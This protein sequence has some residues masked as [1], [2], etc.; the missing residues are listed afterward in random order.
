MARKKKHQRSDGRFEYKATVGRKLDG[1]PIR[2]S[3][4]STSSLT[5]AKRQAEVYKQQQTIAKAEASGTFDA[6]VFLLETGLR[7]GELLGLMWSDIDMER[8]TLHV[9]RSVSP[10]NGRPA[11]R[12]P[13]W[14]SYRTIPLMPDTLALIQRQPK[15]SLYVFPAPRGDGF[16]EP[17]HFSRRVYHFFLSFPEEYR[18]TAHELRHSYASQLMRRGVDIYTISKLPGHHD[19]KNHCRCLCTSGCRSI[20]RGIKSEILSSECRKRSHKLKTVTKKPDFRRNQAFKWSEW[21]DL[22]PRLLDPQSSALPAALHPAIFQQNN[23]SIPANQLQGIFF[24]L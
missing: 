15:R 1:T 19:I 23:D 7:R 22:N 16:E 6:I 18:C 3:F 20:S 13:K 17:N 9:Q 12:P 8:A 21:R 5:D 2:K 4:Y 10:E 24:V 11:V 14:N